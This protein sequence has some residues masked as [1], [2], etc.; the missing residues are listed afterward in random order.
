MS[1]RLSGVIS[2]TDVLN[3]F[4]RAGGSMPMDP[5][6]A[7]KKRRGSSS[8]SIRASMDSN[9]SSSLDLTGSGS[10]SGLRR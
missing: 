9:R 7:R 4:A 10:M 3:L 8:S 6:G 5:D 2:L 1:G